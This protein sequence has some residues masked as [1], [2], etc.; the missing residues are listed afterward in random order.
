M[1]G[2]LHTGRL[3]PQ[4]VG[5][6]SRT[7]TACPCPPQA[8]Q[9]DVHP[10]CARAHL[11]RAWG[12]A[13]TECHQ[14]TSVQAMAQPPD[15]IGL[16]KEGGPDADNRARGQK[17]H[18]GDLTGTVQFVCKVQDR[19]TPTRKA[20]VRHTGLGRG[21]NYQVSFQGT[22]MFYKRLRGRLHS[23]VNTLR[24]TGLCAHVGEV[25]AR[26][27]PLGKA[28]SNGPAQDIELRGRMWRGV[29]RQRQAAPRVAPAH[30][31]LLAAA[32]SQEPWAGLAQPGRMDSPPDHQPRTEGRMEPLLQT[33][34]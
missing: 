18:T 17:P 24:F 4:G 23:P 2:I 16:H 14:C 8:C 20:G 13:D 11:Q 31:R 1:I 30:G 26:E 32:P 29:K 28:A 19:R 3:Q 27:S 25:D 7:S 9:A 33:H 15:C 22:Q 34:E 21:D 5:C 10:V 6:S 12:T